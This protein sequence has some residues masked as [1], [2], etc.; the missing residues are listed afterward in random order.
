MDKVGVSTNSGNEVSV[1]SAYSIAKTNVDQ[2]YINNQNDF[3]SPKY[4]SVLP[5]R[6]QLR[7]SIETVDE[8]DYYFLFTP[9]PRFLL[10]LITMMELLNL[11][12]LLSI[13]I[14]GLLKKMPV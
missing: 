6:Q 12:L 8:V 2:Y 1:A 14:N 10:S 3:K 7:G 13:A 5:K 9:L 4:V 11:K